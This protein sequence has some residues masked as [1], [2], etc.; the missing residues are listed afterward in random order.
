ML[1]L[2]SENAISMFS[3]YSNTFAD[4]ALF[5]FPGLRSAWI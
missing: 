4:F 2:M 5:R 1:Y 3:A